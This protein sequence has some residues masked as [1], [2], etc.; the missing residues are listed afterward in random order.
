M[1]TMEDLKRTLHR[2]DGRGYKTYK[3]IEGVY[4]CREYTLFV[5]HAQGERFG[6]IAERIPPAH[7]FDPSKD[8]REVNIS[9]EGLQSIA[10][11]THTTDLGAVE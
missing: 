3:D 9:S 8:K 7:S 10:F 1:P 11:G 6:G 5:D 4:K 2:I